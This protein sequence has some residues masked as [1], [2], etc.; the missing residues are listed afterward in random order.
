[1][2][3]SS[4]SSK[5]QSPQFWGVNLSNIP[6]SI[7]DSE[8]TAD[9]EQYGT[10]FQIKSISHNSINIV[11]SSAKKQNSLNNIIAQQTKFKVTP[12]ESTQ[13]PAT[14]SKKSSVAKL[15]LLSVKSAYKINSKKSKLSSKA[16][17]FTAGS[18]GTGSS[19]NILDFIKENVFSSIKNEIVKDGMM[20]L[21]GESMAV[22]EMTDPNSIAIL[23]ERIERLNANLLFKGA[24]FSLKRKASESATGSAADKT[25]S[26]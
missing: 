7:T 1:M 10:I 4:S 3:S 13:L 21:P 20:M 26:V 11:F 25:L 18:R 24:K 5:K 9:F 8:I 2:G 6:S 14:K 16:A 23:T 15:N 22:F 17:P 19:S 12:L